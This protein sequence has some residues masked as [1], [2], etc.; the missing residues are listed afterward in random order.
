MYK[1]DQQFFRSMGLTR[2]EWIEGGGGVML[3]ASCNSLMRLGRPV[4]L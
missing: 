3:P 1:M 4:L 2:T